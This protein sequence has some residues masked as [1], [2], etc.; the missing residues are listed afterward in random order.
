MRAGAPVE[1]AWEASW[2]RLIPGVP[3]S[4]IDEDGSPRV[5]SELTKVPALTQIRTFSDIRRIHWLKRGRGRAVHSATLALRSACR[6]SASS[7]APLA[8]ILDAVADGLEESEAAEEARRIASSSARTSSR[9][10]I[11]LPLLGI[12]GAQ[13]MG[14]DPIGTFSDAGIGSV[15]GLIGLTLLLASIFVSRTLI[16]RAAGSA[17]ELDPAI[18]CDLA[19]AVLEAGGSIPQ[20]LEA[21]GESA[22]EPTLRAAGRGLRIGLKWSRAWEERPNDPLALALEPA[23]TDGAMP[24]ELLRRSAR[25][26]RVGR[27][28]DARAKAEALGVELALP[29][30]ALLLP[31]FLA[32][33]LGPVMLHLFEGGFASLV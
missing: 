27:I 11:A 14:A 6:L 21:I 30:G 12:I 18:A 8:Q 33:G 5:L 16:A 20:V 1:H 28:A 26:I 7:G 13:V 31:A 15:L 32:L 9:I 4:G 25:A 23:W 17:G 2:T 22:E 3:F 10:L 29:L 19:Q 24:D